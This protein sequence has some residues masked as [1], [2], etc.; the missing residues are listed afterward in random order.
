MKKYTNQTAFNK[1]Y[2]H[3][4]RKNYVRSVSAKTGRCLYA[5]PEDNSCPLGCFFPRELSLKLDRIKDAKWLDI[6]KN[7]CS[8]AFK[9]RLILRGVDDDL[10]AELQD[11]HD[12]WWSGRDERVEQLD[13][14]AQRFGLTIPKK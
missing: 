5:G 14:I 9:A 10:L 6:I 1:A 3:I 7:K 2:K 12:I 11:I 4:T 8:S 13:A